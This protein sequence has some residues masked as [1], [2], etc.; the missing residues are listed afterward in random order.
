MEWYGWVCAAALPVLIYYW[1][2]EREAARIDRVI[3]ARGWVTTT[4]YKGKEG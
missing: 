2:K 3:E 1:L 4:A